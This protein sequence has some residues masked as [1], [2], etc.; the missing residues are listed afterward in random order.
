[1]I[2]DKLWV[3]LP[4]AKYIDWVLD[5]LRTETKTWNLVTD[6]GLIFV[7]YKPRFMASHKIRELGRDEI[8]SQVWNAVGDLAWY[9]PRQ[10]RVIARDTLLALLA[11]DDSGDLL[12]SDIDHLMI[13]CRLESPAAILLLCAAKIFQRQR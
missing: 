3:D 4:N 10:S 5:D 8:H 7:K 6:S 2:A 1:M 13:M 11:W 12:N 9:S